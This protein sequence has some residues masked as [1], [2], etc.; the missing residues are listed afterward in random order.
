M[1]VP[2]EVDGVVVDRLGT[3]AR[4]ATRAERER[5][6]EDFRTFFCVHLISR[7]ASG[8]ADARDGANG[9]IRRH[10]RGDASRRDRPRRSTGTRG[11]ARGR[12][13]ESGAGGRGRERYE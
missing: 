5:A 9:E 10:P 4:D 12:A 2:S 7:H 11:S 3:R 6:D 1:R 8:A 13:G